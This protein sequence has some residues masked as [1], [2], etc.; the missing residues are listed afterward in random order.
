MTIVNAHKLL[1]NP[2]EISIKNGTT[3][4]LH[5]RLFWVFC[6]PLVIEY[7][8]HLYIVIYQSHLC[9][10]EILNHDKSY[11]TSI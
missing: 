6:S 10:T 9:N 2:R 3:V 8:E 1:N 7:L 11:E 4:T 5:I